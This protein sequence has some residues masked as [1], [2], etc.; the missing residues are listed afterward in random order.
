[1]E[2]YVIEYDTTNTLS[3]VYETRHCVENFDDFD[4]FKNRAIRI[5]NDKDKRNIECYTVS[6]V[7]FDIKTF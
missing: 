6:K 5:R 7:Y 1:M 2:K 3:Y 4:K